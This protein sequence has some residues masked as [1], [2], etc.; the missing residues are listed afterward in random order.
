MFG[1][2]ATGDDE[3][4]GRIHRSRVKKLDAR[5]GV[6]WRVESAGIIG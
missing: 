6:G 5:R 1:L 3:V 2:T 4:G